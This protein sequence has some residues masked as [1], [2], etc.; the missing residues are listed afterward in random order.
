M[1]RVTVIVSKDQLTNFLSYAGQ[2]GVLHFVTVPDK[3]VPTGTI[4]FE[5]SSLVARLA[6]VRN[7][8]TTIA[9][10]MRDSH[11]EPELN[12]ISSQSVESLADYLDKEA[13][14]LERSVKQ[15][16]ARQEKLQEERGRDVQLSRLLSGLE[17][18]GV[19]LSTIGG[20]G[21]T[22]ILAGEALRDSVESI[23]MELDRVS[24][25]NAIFAITN[26]SDEA[27]S[28]FAILPSAF[29]D[30]AKQALAALGARLEPG[31]SEERRVG[32]ECRSRWSPYH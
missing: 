2:E 12:N 15:L 32:K 28:F 23:R 20:T 13:L 31:R 30:E 14:N 16:E 4:P 1:R 27:E 19:R 17:K 9:T 7:R 18:L 22:T 25:G 29:Q 10:L 5:T 26:S 8:L 24:Y 3:Q 11:A 21:F 6:T